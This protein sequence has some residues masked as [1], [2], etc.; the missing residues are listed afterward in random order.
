MVAKWSPVDGTTRL[1]RH[2]KECATLAEFQG[3]PI[4][5]QQ[6]KDV[7]LIIINR[8]QAFSIHY[9]LWKEQPNQRYTN[10]KTWF[11]HAD[12]NRT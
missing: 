12:E 4:S 2:L 1:W 5:E 6:I 3:N 9:L 7:A 8:S 10:L 11:G